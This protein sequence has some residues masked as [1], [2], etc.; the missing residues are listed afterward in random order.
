MNDQNSAGP[1]PEETWTILSRP[2]ETR[3][4]QI[5]REM[6]EKLAAIER[7]RFVSQERRDFINS[8]TYGL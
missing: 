6:E 5:L 1:S 3:R 2:P 4:Q 7:K 8:Q